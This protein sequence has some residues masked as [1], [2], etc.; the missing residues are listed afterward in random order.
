MPRPTPRRHAPTPSARI[1]LCALLLLTLV[2]P[3]GEVAA[4]SPAVEGDYLYR[5]TMLRAAPG[6]FQ[7]LIDALAAQA[8]L[9]VAAGDPAPLTLRH[10]Q[11][12]HWDFMVVQPMESFEAWFTAERATLEASPA[13]TAAGERVARH[14]AFHEEW[15]ARSTGV[16][17]MTRRWRTAGLF[18]VEIFAGLPGR[19]AELVEQRRMENR[20]YAALNRPQNLI[21]TRAAG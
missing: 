21:F 1:P 9:H 2:R 10:S 15:Y 17:E 13:W 12:D 7:A 6:E 8:E 5:V 19:R 20:Y 14:T 3:G 18:H 16:E 11:G 4:Q